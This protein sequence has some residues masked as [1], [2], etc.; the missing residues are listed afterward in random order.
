MEISRY[1]LSMKTLIV[2]LP[3]HEYERIRKQSHE[4]GE[5]MAAI[6]RRALAAEGKHIRDNI[7]VKPMTLN[8]WATDI[9]LRDNFTCTICG[10]K[11]THKTT[12]AHHKLPRGKGGLDTID[13]GTT[14]CFPCHRQIHA[15]KPKTTKEE[16]IQTEIKKNAEKYFDDSIL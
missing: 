3:N 13:N 16:R 6:V 14:L 7:T 1:H 11:G 4:T 2:R 9:K 8:E 10:M 5:S 12:V 15:G